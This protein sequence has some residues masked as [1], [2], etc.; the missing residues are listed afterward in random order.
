MSLAEQI[1]SKISGELKP[2]Y[3][4]VICESDQHHVPPGTAIHFRVVVAT[5]VFEGKNLVARHRLVNAILAEE[6][7][8]PIHA[9]ALHTFTPAE[10]EAKQSATASP[11]CVG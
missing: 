2:V 7:K 5:P 3:L 11:K 4:E 8:G 1:K 10:W 6:L 9:L